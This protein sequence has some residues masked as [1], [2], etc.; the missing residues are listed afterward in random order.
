MKTFAAFAASLLA[1]VSAQPAF[2]AD[3][4]K[5]VVRTYIYSYDAIDA[6]G[7]PADLVTRRKQDA[8]LNV[9]RQPDSVAVKSDPVLVPLLLTLAN[10]AMSA[11]EQEIQKKEKARL[12]SLSSTYTAN[13]SLA[14]MPVD[15]ANSYDCL[16]V[17][18]V[19]EGAGPTANRA[20]YVIGMHRVG[21]NGMRF[22]P[23]AARIDKSKAL[24]D[25][26]KT[27]K[28][29]SEVTLTM[30]AVAPRANSFLPELYTYPAYTISFKDM[31]EG[32]NHSA[33]S[34]PMSAVMPL[35]AGAPGDVPVT[36]AAAVTESHVS[37]DSEKERIALEQTNR[38]AISAAIG[39]MLKAHMS[40]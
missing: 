28:L 30:T 29:N 12:K 26:E 5:P 8:L 7:L 20:T 23:L 27:R 11:V 33:A 24:P 32:Q 1:S 36:I 37:L 38:K 18:H 34:L 3:G 31:I 10:F 39:E 9:C 17:D 22:E 25:K 6:A 21:N 35:P 14:A 16:V 19:E 2:A 4:A 13:R 15:S 40:E